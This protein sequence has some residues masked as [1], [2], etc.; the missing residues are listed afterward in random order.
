MLLLL[1]SV[2]IT[3]ILV[4][5]ST[6]LLCTTLRNNII[7]VCNVVMVLF[8]HYTLCYVHVHFVNKIVYTYMHMETLSHVLLLLCHDRLL[9]PNAD[10]MNNANCKVYNECYCKISV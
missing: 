3:V 4:F 1:R 7:T 10:S 5:I 8:L 2:I 6:L 9:L